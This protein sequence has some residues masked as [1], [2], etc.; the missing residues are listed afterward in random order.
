[1]HQLIV[2]KPYTFSPPSKGTLW[3]KLFQLALPWY[4]RKYH[5]VTSVSFENVERL[6]ASIASG[7][8]VMLTPNHCR[9]CD[10]MVVTALA[11]L[12]GSPMYIMASRHLFEQGRLQKWL[13]QHAGAFSVFREGMDREALKLAIDTLKEAKRPL[14]LFPEGVIT[15]TNDRLNSLMEGTSFIA[16]NAAKGSREGHVVVHPLAIRYKFCGDIEAALSPVLS[17]I[18]SRLTWSPRSRSLQE[19]I[20]A[21]GQALLSLKE[22]EFLGRPQSGDIAER[23]VGLTNAILVPLEQEWFKSPGK[24]DVVSRVKKLRAAIIPDLVGKDLTEEDKAQR[25]SQLAQVY[26]AQQLYFYPPSYTHNATQERLLE[27]VERFEEDLKDVATIHAPIHATIQVGTA[28]PVSSER[29][30]GSDTVMLAIQAQLSQML[31]I[32][33]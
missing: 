24:G 8:G 22:T 11:K 26:L 1:M 16:R 28:I 7:H 5:G 9:P 18:E 17:E 19:R 32:H 13:L 29:E 10:P 15:R 33:A 30:K 31:G 2:E 27:T 20:E 12:T 25:W 21:V 23:L 6:Q 14:V 4:L 3:P